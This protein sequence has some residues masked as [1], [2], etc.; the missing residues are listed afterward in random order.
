MKNRS[1]FKLVVIV[2]LVAVIC[3]VVTLLA[4]LVAG[5]LDAELLNFENLNLSNVLVVLLIGGF[6][7]S[8]VIGLS[9]LFLT[10]TAYNKF[11]EYLNENNNHKGETK[12]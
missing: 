9:F 7:S 8:A 4:A 10:R 12:K 5:A 6:I 3:F 11:R 1:L 2:V